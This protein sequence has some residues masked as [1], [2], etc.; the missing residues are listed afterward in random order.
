MCYVHGIINGLGHNTPWLN[1]CKV[2]GVWF[3][4]GCSSVQS[5]IA[6]KKF[7]IKNIL[8]FDFGLVSKRFEE[9]FMA[10]NA[11]KRHF[12]HASLRI[13]EM[14]HL[15]LIFYLLW[16]RLRKNTIENKLTF[17]SHIR[18]LCEKPPRKLG[19]SQGY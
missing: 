11:D 5:Q 14:K 16:Q 13:R 18:I 7:E 10:L 3:F 15:S 12:V 9:N 4:T 19:L 6:Y 17:N 2:R 8:H 1:D